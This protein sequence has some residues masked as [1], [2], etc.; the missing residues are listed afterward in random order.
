MKLGKTLKIAVI[1][2]ICI[3]TIVM[4]SDFMFLFNGK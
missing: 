2:L 3:M 4:L 1:V